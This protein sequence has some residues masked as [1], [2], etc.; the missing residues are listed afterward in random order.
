M[1]YQSINNDYIKS[2]KKL[3]NKK[4]RDL[5]NLFIVEGEHLVNE[6]IKNN[7][8]KTLIL[9][10]TEKTNFNGEV[11]YVS[12]NVM[13][14][15]TNLTSIPKM[16][17]VCKKIQSKE[18]GNKVVIL[19]NIQDPGNLGTIIRSCVAFNIDTL[20]ISNNSV[21]LYNPKVI[22]ATQ[23][24]IFNLNI[25]Q[26]DVTKTIQNLKQKNYKI[27]G[28]KVDGGKELNTIEKLE[29]FAIIMGNEGNG[30]TDEVSNLCDE[31]IYI[32]MNEKC[33]SLNVAV[34]TSII[35]YT[36]NGG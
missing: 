30:M 12:E 4:Y 15:L 27:L 7:Y 21:D 18:I 23:G 5:T 13:K 9:L 17:G 2:L 29:N 22:R 14:Y 33:E 28:T 10:D 35:L 16:I 6:A 34:A 20:V 26:E 8:L 32:K 36:I 3:E 1:L 19:D 31:F 11:K 24:L 25:I